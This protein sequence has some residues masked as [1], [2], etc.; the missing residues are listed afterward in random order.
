MRS[1]DSFNFPLGL[2]KYIVIVTFVRMC[3]LQIVVGSSLSRKPK[4][5]K[6]SP[7][8]TTLTTTTTTWSATGS[9]RY[10]SLS[11][12]PF[13]RNINCVRSPRWPI[14]K[15]RLKSVQ[16]QASVQTAQSLHAVHICAKIINTNF[17]FIIF[18][19]CTLQPRFSFGDLRWP[20]SVR[21]VKWA[22]YLQFFG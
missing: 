19:L 7:L 20:R 2:I 3:M 17:V 18:E 6:S 4:G 21:M 10:T 1:N 5:K 8:Q 22:R 12:G 9:S 16:W 11:R 13:P 15:A 14:R